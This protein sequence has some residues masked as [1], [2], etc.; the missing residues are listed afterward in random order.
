VPFRPDFSSFGSALIQIKALPG[1]VID[2]TRSQSVIAREGALRSPRRV[3]AAQPNI[4]ACPIAKIKDVI[5]AV[6]GSQNLIALNTTTNC[7]NTSP[8]RTHA[9]G[10][11]RT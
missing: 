3:I 9:E 2:N 4:V 6:E 7:R 11:T 10:T 5:F 1:I 8:C